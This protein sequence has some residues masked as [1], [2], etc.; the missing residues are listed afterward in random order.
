M[1]IPLVTDIEDMSEGILSLD[2]MKTSITVALSEEQG[3]NDLFLF[4][5]HF[6][7]SSDRLQWL[8][9]KELHYFVFQYFRYVEDGIMRQGI[10]PPALAFRTR[11]AGCDCKTLAYFIYTVL[12]HLHLPR[13]MILLE[14]EPIRQPD[15]IIRQCH[16]FPSTWILGKWWYL[17]ASIYDFNWQ[18]IKG[19]LSIIWEA[20]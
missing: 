15:G 12:H 7:Q 17:D 1:L 13:Q 10:K 18:P 9:L 8:G 11:N 3:M 16:L 19:S 14:Y 6:E 5:K 2:Q 4:S 20:Y